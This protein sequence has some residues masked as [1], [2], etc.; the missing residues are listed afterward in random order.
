MMVYTVRGVGLA[1]VT[2][3]TQRYSRTLRLAAIRATKL[4]VDTQSDYLVWEHKRNQMHTDGKVAFVARRQG[5]RKPIA[6]S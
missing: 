6:R 3:A 1:P 5:Y 2:P 4:S